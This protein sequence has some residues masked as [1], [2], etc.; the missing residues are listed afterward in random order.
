LRS[1]AYDHYKEVDMSAQRSKSSIRNRSA[2]RLGA[3]LEKSLSAYAV[4][5]TAAGVSLLALAPSAQARIVYTRANTPIPVNGGPV[6]LDLNHD[7]VVDFSFS[8]RVRNSSI[9][10]LT[11]FILHALPNGR[12]NAIWGRGTF[13]WSRSN[14]SGGFAGALHPGFTV[15]TTRSYFQK[16]KNG[17]LGFYKIAASGGSETSQT[18]GQWLNTRSRYLGLQ[19]LIDGQVHYGWARLSV[20]LISVTKTK[21]IQATLTGYAYETIPNKPIITGKTKGPDVITLDQAT[22]GRLAQGASGVSVWR[23]KK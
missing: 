15:G 6:P 7:G 16:G 4:A 5:A 8:N 1:L 14:Y 21:G 10:N 19:F 3:G 17:V 23:E 13:F 18:Y 12:S 20:G 22:L 11:S 9:D 2:I